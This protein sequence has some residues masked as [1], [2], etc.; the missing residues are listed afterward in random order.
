MWRR[1]W[2]NLSTKHL[3]EK[4]FQLRQF[5]LDLSTMFV[6]NDKGNFED[7]PVIARSLVEF[8][9]NG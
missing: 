8:L 9:E 2:F 5:A 1:S 4:T 3:D 7:I 6:I